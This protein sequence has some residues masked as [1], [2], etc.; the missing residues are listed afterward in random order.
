MKFIAVDI[1][2]VLCT[3]NAQPFLENLSETFNITIQEAQY[4]LKRF[5]RIHD[6]GHTTMEDELREKFNVKSKII[7]NKMVQSWNNSIMPYV[8]IL[9]KFNELKSKYDLQV[10]LLSNIGIEHAEMME[11]KLKHNGFFS[12]A[13]KH[14]SCDVGIRKPS[15]IFYQSFI[16]QYPKFKGCLYVD[17][18]EDNLI[19]GAKFEFKPFKFDL[20]ETLSVSE[21]ILE[22]EKIIIEE[23]I[24]KNSR[25]H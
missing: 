8:P 6:L 16:L 22:I 12:D 2:N 25:W 1:G 7:I 10:A 24:I 20:D 15:S 5:Q 18:L 11:E 17:D 4:F 23:P 9:N 13:I 3:V 14:F 21:K 19:A